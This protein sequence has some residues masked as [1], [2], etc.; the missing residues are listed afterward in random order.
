MLLLLLLLVLPWTSGTRSYTE[1]IQEKNNQ[2]LNVKGTGHPQTTYESKM[3]ANNCATGI[4][5]HL[6]AHAVVPIRE[7]KVVQP[8]T[9]VFPD[10]TDHVRSEGLVSHRG[11]RPELPIC[12]KK[13]VSE[14]RDRGESVVYS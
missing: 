1:P 10:E 4:R 6:T 14:L 11:C 12:R 3:T 13:P 5:A 8:R 7:G 2:S 9:G